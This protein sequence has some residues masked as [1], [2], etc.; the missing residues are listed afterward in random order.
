MGAPRFCC[1]WKPPMAP[2]NC[3]CCMPAWGMGGGGASRSSRTKIWRPMSME[4]LSIWITTCASAGLASSTMPQP[5][6]LPSG[7]VRTSAR[8]GL[9]PVVLMWSL[10]SL[11]DTP[12]A[13]LPTKQRLDWATPMGGCCTWGGAKPLNW[14]GWGVRLRK[15]I[16]LSVGEKAYLRQAPS[17]A[18][19]AWCPRGACRAAG[20]MAGG[21]VRRRWGGVG[22]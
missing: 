17:A 19:G 6:L 3:C 8:V 1:C 11:H 12:Q 18:A 2:P 7:S 5:L 16:I 20:G 14:P 9:S 22:G 4:L 21:K 10:S 13:R 15:F